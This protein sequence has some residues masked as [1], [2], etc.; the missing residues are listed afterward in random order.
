MSIQARM[1]KQFCWVVTVKK[2]IPVAR[3][4]CKPLD[5]TRFSYIFLKI[6]GVTTAIEENGFFGRELLL[7][8]EGVL[9]K[10]AN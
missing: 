10:N 8:K 5:C 1:L 2:T 7:D 9:T 3:L 6:A 4:D